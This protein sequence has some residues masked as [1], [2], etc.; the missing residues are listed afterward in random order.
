M[1]LSSNLLD[2]WFVMVA[3]V[4]VVICLVVF[5]FIAGR[6]IKKNQ[7]QDALALSQKE[8]EQSKIESQRLSDLESLHHANIELLEGKLKIARDR[9][10]QA[11]RINAS[12]EEKL[13]HLSNSHKSL[14]LA[15]EEKEGL[16]IKLAET[17]SELDFLQKKINHE[18]SSEQRLSEI[19]KSTASKLFDEKSQ[20]FTIQ[21]KESLTGLLVPFREQI[22][23]FKQQVE[24]AYNEENKERRSLQNEVKSLQELNRN[25]SEEA[26]N[27]TKA[28]KGDKKLQGNWGEVVL[29]RVLEESGLREGHEYE[30]QQSF[31]TEEGK[32]QQP[33]VIVHLP[34][35]KIVIID[36]KV[37]LVDYSKYHVASSK[38]E[39][40]TAL[41][42][43]VT[44][45]Q[46]HIKDLGEKSY[47]ALKGIKTLDYVLMFIPVE[48]AFYIA[49]ENQPSLFQYAL[50]KNIMLVSPTNLLVALK[51]IH[52]I[53]SYELQNRNTQKIVDK[54]GAI[55]DK[56]QGLTED[57]LKLGLQLEKASLTYDK[58][59]NKFKTGRG[60]L[61]KQ[62]DDFV[63]LKVSIKKKIN[64]SLT[65]EALS[66]NKSSDGEK[67]Y[68]NSVVS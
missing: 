65:D 28:L 8:L 6:V 11:E 63:N 20:R 49:I 64:Q 10:V 30:T 48:S 46:Q 36:S 15:S 52:H 26:S 1:V 58:A 45:I 42:A 55:Y 47:Q 67:A 50:D 7:M 35:E 53:W 5:A 38:T 41:K 19:F 12:M 9:E 2:F 29:N 4:I 27:L 43:H 59:I 17:R 22:E 25:I 60:N 57:M 66:S 32:K 56:L 21:N 13:L 62:A 51:T 33:D 31:V 39:Q 44:A 23:G 18:M 40:A 61:L 16:K 3:V 34:D 68:D 14:R 37:S 54:A 24:Q